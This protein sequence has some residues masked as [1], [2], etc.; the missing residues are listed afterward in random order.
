MFEPL[1]DAPLRSMVCSQ[2]E[3]AYASSGIVLWEERRPV[4]D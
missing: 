1:E 3:V 4:E 2:D